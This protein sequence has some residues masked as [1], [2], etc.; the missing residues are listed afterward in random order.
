M[1]NLGSINDSKSIVT[2]GYTDSTYAQ[3]SDVASLTTKVGGVSDSLDEVNNKIENDVPKSQAIADYTGVEPPTIDADTL[4]GKYRSSD[5]DALIDYRNSMINLPL[6]IDFSG[7]WEG[8]ELKA[9]KIGNIVNIYGNGLINTV[10]EERVAII[11]ESIRPT[12]NSAFSCASSK[13]CE[14][15]CVSINTNGELFI[16]INNFYAWY[17]TGT[18]YSFNITYVI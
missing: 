6:D 18:H 14:N 7:H 11:P 2:K 9:I 1:K 4:G 13:D 16:A 15:A 12:H 10:A 17:T 3:K 8:S 5:I